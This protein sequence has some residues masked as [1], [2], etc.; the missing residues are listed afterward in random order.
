MII[1]WEQSSVIQKGWGGG[2]DKNKSVIQELILGLY[3][4]VKK[5]NRTK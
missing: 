5:K 4:S 2:G 3:F 1:D